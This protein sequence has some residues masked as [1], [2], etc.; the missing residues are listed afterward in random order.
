MNQTLVTQLKLTNGDPLQFLNILP[1]FFSIVLV[2]LV[3][4]KLIWT[5]TYAYR[6]HTYML[7]VLRDFVDLLPRTASKVPA[8]EWATP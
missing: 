6:K 2:K 8:T 4:I 3:H 7:Y 1:L 5:S